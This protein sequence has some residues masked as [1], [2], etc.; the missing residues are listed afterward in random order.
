MLMTDKISATLYSY[1]LKLWKCASN[2]FFN[3]GVKWSIASNGFYS[4]KDQI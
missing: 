2:V 1:K 4:L 3:S